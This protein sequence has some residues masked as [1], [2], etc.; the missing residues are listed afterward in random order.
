M[1]ATHTIESGGSLYTLSTVPTDNSFSFYSSI[2]LWF[3]GQI[4]IRQ[5]Q[6][7]YFFLTEVI[8]YFDMDNLIECLDKVCFF[9][10][11]VIHPLNTQHTQWYIS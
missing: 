2:A 1:T 4:L 8:H 5:S 3:Q 9:G 11:E 10:T 6:M 7:Y